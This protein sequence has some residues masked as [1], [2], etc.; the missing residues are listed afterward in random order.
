MMPSVGMKTKNLD[1]DFVSCTIL[2]QL[3]RSF[4]S[5]IE[6]KWLFI[7]SS[8]APGIRLTGIHG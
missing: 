1:S 8:I 2:R 4:L 3:T 7:P 6:N 5:L